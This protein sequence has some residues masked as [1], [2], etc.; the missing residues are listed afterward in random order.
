M[1]MVQIQGL[2]TARGRSVAVVVFERLPLS[3]P[4]DQGLRDRSGGAPSPAKVSAL[5]ESWFMIVAAG[6]AGRQR[7]DFRV[8]AMC[9]A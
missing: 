7:P 2:W 3:T 8:A 1:A 6:G 4:S 9:L 5:H